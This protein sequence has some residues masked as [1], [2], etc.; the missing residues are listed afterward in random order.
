MKDVMTAQ[1]RVKYDAWLRATQNQW[2]KSLDEMDPVARALHNCRIKFLIL[3][4]SKK[5]GEIWRE[6][7]ERWYS[8][9]KDVMMRHGIKKSDLTAHGLS[10]GACAKLYHAAAH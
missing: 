4:E 1:D 3:S 6:N 5:R 9:L 8:H 2:L 7:V 10:W